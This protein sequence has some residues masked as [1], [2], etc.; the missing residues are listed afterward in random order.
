MY[1]EANVKT[2]DLSELPLEDYSTVL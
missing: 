2:I 1:V